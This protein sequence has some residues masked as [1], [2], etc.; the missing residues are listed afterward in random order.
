MDKGYHP[1]T[2]YFPLIIDQAMMFEPT[3]TESKETLDEFIEAMI[4][5]AREAK[6]NPD[7][8]KNAPHSTIVRRPDE[9]RAARD[10]ILKYDM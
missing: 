2:V 1:P 4:E 6:D 10:P 7:I 8:L 5:I 3:E 9:T